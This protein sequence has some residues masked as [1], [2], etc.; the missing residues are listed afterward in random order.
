MIWL[1]MNYLCQEQTDICFQPWDYLII[2][3]LNVDHH[4]N[5]ALI[6]AC[7]NSLLRPQ[8]W[9]Y[10]GYCDSA[11]SHGQRS[12]HWCYPWVIRS[13]SAYGS[14]SHQH[15]ATPLPMSS[16]I[17]TSPTYVYAV[18]HPDPTTSYS[19]SPFITHSNTPPSHSATSFN[20]FSMPTHRQHWR[21]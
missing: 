4:T 20:T 17:I 1:E 18:T 16:P 8:Q 5:V 15:V 10:V 12:C 21:P 7:F 9:G 6:P 19:T 13:W 3:S 2:L 11:C 14:R